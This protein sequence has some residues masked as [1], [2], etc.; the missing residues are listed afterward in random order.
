MKVKVKTC[1][2]YDFQILLLLFI[3]LSD[4]AKSIIIFDI[5]PWDD[6]TDINAMEQAI[7]SIEADGLLWGQCK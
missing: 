7:R 1:F 4:I 2:S 5:K 6:E 3:Y